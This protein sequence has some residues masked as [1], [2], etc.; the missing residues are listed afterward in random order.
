MVAE[1]KSGHAELNYP[2]GRAL[3]LS[4]FPSIWISLKIYLNWEVEKE[5]IV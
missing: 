4:A 5:K 2:Q 1:R 3:L